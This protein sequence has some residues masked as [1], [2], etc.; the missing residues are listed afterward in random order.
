MLKDCPNKPNCVST[1]ASSTRQR[2]PP[3]KPVCSDEEAIQQVAEVVARYPRTKMVQQEMHYLHATFT[4]RVLRFV[5]D[6][7]F[8]MENG[9]LHFRSASRIGYSDLGAN[10]KRMQ[11]IVEDLLQRG[12]E[13]A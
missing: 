6:V 7:E 2:M 1:R 12:F 9:L 10:R 3:L 4:S 8:E 5:D 13:L 11:Q